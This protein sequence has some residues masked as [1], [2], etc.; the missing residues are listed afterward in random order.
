MV[1]NDRNSDCL[2]INILSLLLKVYIEKTTTTINNKPNKQTKQNKNA[3]RQKEKKKGYGAGFEPGT[4][5]STRLHLTTTHAS[6]EKSLIQ[7]LFHETSAGKRLVFGAALAG[8]VTVKKQ[9][10]RITR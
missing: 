9:C 6:G 3:K 1:G 5:G 2:S 8:I 7:F 10:K 4:F